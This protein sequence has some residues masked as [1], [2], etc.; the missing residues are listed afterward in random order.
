MRIGFLGLIAVM[1]TTPA[2]AGPCG[3]LC[4]DMDDGSGAGRPDGGVT[5]EDLL[6]FLEHYEAGD[7]LITPFC[8]CFNPPPC[9]DDTGA[10]V[11]CCSS[12]TGEGPLLWFLFSYF[13]AC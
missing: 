13:E 8:E 7:T 2:L 5:I 9:I 1:L 12:Q 11:D 3:S 4:A 10:P 6:Y